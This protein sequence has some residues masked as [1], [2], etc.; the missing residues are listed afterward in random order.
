MQ[1]TIQ[2]EFRA[3]QPVSGSRTVDTQSYHTSDK[4]YVGATYSVVATEEEIA[5]HYRAQL[6]AKGWAY[7]GRREILDNGQNLGGWSDTYCNGGQ[8]AEVDYSGERA[9][10]G[11]TYSIS[12]FWGSASRC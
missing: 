12:I 6:L 11:W 5:N 3:I 10:Y 2:T 1:G 8:E 4:A 7:V 9:N